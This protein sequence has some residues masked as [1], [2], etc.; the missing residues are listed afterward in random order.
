MGHPKFSRPKF[1]TPK[2]PWKKAR[3]DEEH[4]IAARHGLKNMKE[5]WNCLLYTSPS[6]RDS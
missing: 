6:P 5:I 3:I 1:D 2:H 4:D